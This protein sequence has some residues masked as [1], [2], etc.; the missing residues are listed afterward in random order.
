MEHRA[1]PINTILDFRGVDGVLVGFAGADDGLP[2][3]YAYMERWAADLA[4]LMENPLGH[5]PVTFPSEVFLGADYTIFRDRPA[6][7]EVYHTVVVNPLRQMLHASAPCFEIHEDWLT[8]GVV[9]TCYIIRMLPSKTLIL[10]KE[11]AIRYPYSVLEPDGSYASL[12]KLA[13]SAMTGLI[14]MATGAGGCS[15]TVVIDGPA[16]ESVKVRIRGF[17]EANVDGSPVRIT[18]FE[19][20]PESAQPGGIV[21]DDS[22]DPV[23]GTKRKEAGD[24]PASS[25]SKRQRTPPAPPPAAEDS[26]ADADEPGIGGGGF[27]HTKDAIARLLASRTPAA[28]DDSDTE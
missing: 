22:A 12:P 23:V 7:V 24:G 10:I 11:T 2:Y 25:S 13:L 4:K 28:E 17:I 21:L 6:N 19:E 3:Y 16:S 15:D 14:A 18:H 1:D 27:L 8:P 5:G 26:T 20:P 9:H